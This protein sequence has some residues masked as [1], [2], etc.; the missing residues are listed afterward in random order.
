MK[1]FFFICCF[2]L[3][4]GQANTFGINCCRSDDVDPL[5]LLNPSFTIKANF[6]YGTEDENKL[7]LAETEFY[8]LDKSLVNILKDGKFVPEFSDRRRRHKLKESD[9]LTA[10]AKAFISE[11]EESA[12]IAMLIKADVSKHKLFTLK[13][14]YS[15][16]AKIKELKIGTYYLFGIGKTDGEI[17]VWH[18]IVNIKSFN[19]AV[20]LD[21]YN[22]EVVFSVED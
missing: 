14:D 18:S 17:F 5:T 13:T 1:K 11:D 9:Y 2:L 21:Q 22:A 20:E 12:L 16:Q 8:L 15:G 7:P 6:Y 3:L 4:I 19:N 10:A